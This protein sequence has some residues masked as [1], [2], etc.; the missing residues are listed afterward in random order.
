[1]GTKIGG[2]EEVGCCDGADHGGPPYQLVRTSVHWHLSSLCYLSRTLS[3]LPVDL[4]RGEE[5]IKRS[6]YW[7]SFRP[8]GLY[9]IIPK[10]KAA[11]STRSEILSE[12]YFIKYIKIRNSENG[13]DGLGPRLL[14]KPKN[15]GQADNEDLYDSHLS[16]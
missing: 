10:L 12:G 4:R 16:G 3:V 11:H 9:Y 15:Q 8:N 5:I 2:E 1:M 14:R 6:T 7:A 13:K